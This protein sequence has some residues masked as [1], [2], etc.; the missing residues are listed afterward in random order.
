MWRMLRAFIAQ[1][2]G[3]LTHYPSQRPP[4]RL[5]ARQLA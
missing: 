4:R 3:S 2:N 1:L 5:H